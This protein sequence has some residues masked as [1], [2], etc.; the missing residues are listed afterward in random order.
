MSGQLRDFDPELVTVTWALPGGAVDLTP[1]LIDAQNAIRSAKAVPRASR[2]TDRQGNQVRRRTRN[3]S[4]SLFLT[5]QAE[6]QLQ[7]TLTAIIALEDG[8]VPQV[9]PITVRNLNGDEL[10]VYLGA[11]IDND[12]DEAFGSEA[13]DRVYEFGYAKREAA[14]AG[15][16]AVGG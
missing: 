2:K 13:T 4:G 8:G 15:T 11:A 10:Y 16:E 5:Y 9:G 7:A 14:N 3:K 12:P 6:S 1:G